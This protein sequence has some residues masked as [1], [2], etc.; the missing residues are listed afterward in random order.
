MHDIEST[1]YMASYS[2][3]DM[4]GLELTKFIKQS[5]ITAH[6]FNSKM[7]NDLNG[8]QSKAFFNFNDSSTLAA[9]LKKAEETI[10]DIVL[11]L[12]PL[13][14]NSLSTYFQNVKG[15]IV[16]GSYESLAT[17]YLTIAVIEDSHQ[18]TFTQEEQMIESSAVDAAKFQ[19]AIRINISD[20][21][22]EK[23]K[24]SPITLFKKTVSR[25][26]T[27][28]AETVLDCSES[29]N[30]RTASRLIVSAVESYVQ[31][32]NVAASEE[33]K[34]SIKKEAARFCRE[35]SAA[36]MP[37][38]IS[39][40][41]GAISSS[42]KSFEEHFYSLSDNLAGEVSIQTDIVNSLVEY[43]GAG[44]GLKIQFKDNLL[45]ERISYDIASDTLVIK[46]IPPNL[47]DQLLRNGYKNKL[48]DTVSKNDITM[49]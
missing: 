22:T 35:A 43:K 38:V 18:F 19:L 29:N 32:E 26:S 12:A 8:R 7:H 49:P 47:K 16:I 9:D 30:T 15:Y 4:E 6:T 48:E 27:Q 24:N 20:L 5:D 21:K 46:G 13:I 3:T 17:H 11:Q 39:E 31:S 2:I 41:S 40:F 34:A 28:F 45:G 36:G 33:E 10:D 1:L 44:G 25:R 14:S 23:C 42:E 37:V